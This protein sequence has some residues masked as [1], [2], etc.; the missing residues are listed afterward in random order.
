MGWQVFVLEILKTTDLM[1]IMGLSIIGFFLYDRAVKRTT[2]SENKLNERIDKSENRLNE[3][4]DKS[5]NNL[6]E[7]VNQSENRLREL[8]NQSEN[9]LNERIDRLENNLRDLLTATI[10]PIQEQVYNH[11]PTQIKAMEEKFDR[12]F[13]TLYELL[14]NKGK[15]V[16]KEHT[17][18]KEKP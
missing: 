6:R 18:D 17:K 12:K 8:V 1:T 13:D 14:L 15:D 10:K 16:K 9:R 11:I 3:R 4:I 2:R 5:E 7:L